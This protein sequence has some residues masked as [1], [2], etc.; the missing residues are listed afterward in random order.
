MPATPLEAATMKMP[1][2]ITSRS[3]NWSISRPQKGLIASR[4]AAK[5]DTTAPTA[6]LSTPKLRANTGSTGT[7]TPKPTA[8]QKAI[9]PSTY[10]SRGRPLEP[11]SR[12][13]TRSGMPRCVLTGT[14][15][16]AARGTVRRRSDPDSGSGGGRGG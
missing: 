10:T 3:P 15:C 8:T 11:R 5:A 9:R 7:R 2:A 1:T 13:R 6:K 12:S 16:L 4:R 14:V